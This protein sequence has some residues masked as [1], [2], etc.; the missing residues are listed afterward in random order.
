MWVQP[1]GTLELGERLI[2][3]A[4][5]RIHLR[6]T[7]VGAEE[8]RLKVERLQIGCLRV[9]KVAPRAMGLAQEKLQL[10]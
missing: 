6:Q 4:L 7:E 5:L 10:A 9:C 8:V 1:E 3:V 2:V